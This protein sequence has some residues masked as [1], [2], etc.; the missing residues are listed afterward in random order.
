MRDEKFIV[1]LGDTVE[2]AKICNVTPQA[3]SQWKNKG[4]PSARMMYLKLRFP[5]KYAQVYQP[6]SKDAA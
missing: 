4:I 1:E 2:V 5:K 6:E 3:V